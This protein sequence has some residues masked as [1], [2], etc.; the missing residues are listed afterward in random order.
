M[1]DPSELAPGWYLTDPFRPDAPVVAGPFATEEEAE[2]DRMEWNTGG[3][4]NVE[5]KR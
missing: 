5:R 4:L 2:A 3:D 1:Y